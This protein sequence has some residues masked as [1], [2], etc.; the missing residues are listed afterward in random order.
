M[1]KTFHISVLIARKLLLQFPPKNSSTNP[2]LYWQIIALYWQATYQ[3][4]LNA[5]FQFQ[6]T[7]FQISLL[8][9][10]DYSNLR[11]QVCQIKPFSS[12]KRLDSPPKKCSTLTLK[13]F[14]NRNW[15]LFSVSV[16]VLTR[17][18]PLRISDVRLYPEA[19]SLWKLLTAKSFFRKRLCRKYLTEFWLHLCL[20]VLKYNKY[21]K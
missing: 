19:Y 2:T 1:R 11:S 8:L 16:L 5:W 6:T 7:L 13:I 10:I 15:K 3:F 4:I 21:L 17:H 12:N 18:F 14:H 9:I 20:L